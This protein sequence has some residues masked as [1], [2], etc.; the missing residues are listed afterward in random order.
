VISVSLCAQA[1]ELCHRDDVSV[2]AL[3]PTADAADS[4]V[5]SAASDGNTGSSWNFGLRS[6][7]LVPRTSCDATSST[8]R[9]A[10]ITLQMLD[11]VYS[12]IVGLLAVLPTGTHLTWRARHL[13]LLRLVDPGYV[14]NPL[15]PDPAKL[16]R[17]CAPLIAKRAKPRS[18]A[19]PLSRSSGHTV[20][21]DPS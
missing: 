20:S 2:V 21:A 13:E 11:W 15:I 10:T 1:A 16:L 8:S 4:A 19:T 14:D 18:R 3:G 17:S 5:P 9:R 6:S 12:V 7:V